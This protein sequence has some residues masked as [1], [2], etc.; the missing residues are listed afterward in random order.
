MEREFTFE[1]KVIV[2]GEDKAQIDDRRAR[3]FA[4]MQHLNSADWIEGTQISE[5]SPLKETN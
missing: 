3:L 5:L 2:R 1:V 4:Y